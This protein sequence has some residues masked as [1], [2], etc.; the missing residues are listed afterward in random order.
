MQEHQVNIANVQPLQ[1]PLYGFFRVVK[2]RG[3]DFGGDEN[4]LPWHIA[5]PNGT[6]DTLLVSIVRDSVNEPPAVFQQSCNGIVAFFVGK[7]IGAEPR[8]RHFI[9]AVQKYCLLFKIKDRDRRFCA[10]VFASQ[11]SFLR[12][13]R[14]G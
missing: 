6:S 1:T 2:F 8:N 4:F 5:V 13:R 7:S 10:G 3:V 9:A 14:C 12:R 11:R